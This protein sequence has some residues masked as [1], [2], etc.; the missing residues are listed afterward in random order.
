MENYWSKKNPYWKTIAQIIKY[1]K[2]LVKSLYFY[3]YSLLVSVRSLVDCLTSLL[4]ESSSTAYCT[5][6]SAVAWLWLV[7][8]I[9]LR[10][11]HSSSRHSDGPCS[12]T[13]LVQKF[14]K[15]LPLRFSRRVRVRF[16]QV[17]SAPSAPFQVLVEFSSLAPIRV[18]SSFSCLF[19][20]FLLSPLCNKIFLVVDP[21][22]EGRVGGVSW[23][24][25][26]FDEFVSAI[27]GRFIV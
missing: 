26:E 8:S 7:D 10:L 4:D 11:H 25:V 13:V 18:S 9:L 2:S 6:V 5:T 19:F 20:L 14:A 12:V 27:V 16:A 21:F 15:S 17:I 22:V 23:E 3:W 1:W 24:I